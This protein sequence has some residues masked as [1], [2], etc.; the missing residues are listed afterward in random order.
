MWCG[1][2]GCP[3]SPRKEVQKQFEKQ[4]EQSTADKIFID[5]LLPIEVFIG[6]AL[7]VVAV[8]IWLLGPKSRGLCCAVYFAGIAGID[9]LTLS[10]PGVLKY[11]YRAELLTT[12]VADKNKDNPELKSICLVKQ[13]TL[14]PFLQSSNWITATLTLERPLTVLFPFVFRSQGMRKRSRYVVI[15]IFVVFLSIYASVT[16]TQFDGSA[17]L[18]EDLETFLNYCFYYKKTN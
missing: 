2:R 4:F 3:V 16:L 15:A 11:L 1:L 12:E 6:I 17:A 18:Y 9:L 13:V 10:I 14:P 7:N 8:C 5:T